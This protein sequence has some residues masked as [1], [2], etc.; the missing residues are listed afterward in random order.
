MEDCVEGL[1]VTKVL[2]GPVAALL[3]LALIGCAES[4]TPLEL[5]NARVRLPVPGTDKSVAYFDVTNTTAAPITLVSA[6]SNGARAIEFH[7]MI[8]DGDM[9]RMRRL[10]EVEIAPGATVEFA[11]GGKHLM[12]FGVTELGAVVEIVLTDADGVEY[13]HGFRT[14]SATGAQ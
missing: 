3:T 5:E 7:T 10:T 2:A 13:A 9:M 4:A 11:P 6:S 1:F 8:R 14:F 12:M